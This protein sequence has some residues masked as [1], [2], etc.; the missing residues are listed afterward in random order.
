[1]EIVKGSFFEEDW[2]TGT[3]IVYFANAVFS[4]EVIDKLS[5]LCGN[6]KEGARIAS[7]K[8]MAE[9]SYLKLYF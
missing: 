1:M 2:T 6:L 7:L 5:D 8:P 3:D 4:D 9:R